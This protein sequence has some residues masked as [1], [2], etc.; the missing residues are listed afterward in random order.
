M[1]D[2]DKF[3]EQED[4]HLAAL[5]AKDTAENKTFDDWG[6]RLEGRREA[7]DFTLRE[8]EMIRERSGHTRLGTQKAGDLARE[9]RA[10]PFPDR[11][12]ERDGT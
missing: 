11:G 3:N 5:S 4:A 12:G 7:K 2:E 9:D 6:N 10:T 1:F 8:A